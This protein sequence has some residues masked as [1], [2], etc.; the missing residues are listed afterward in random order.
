MPPNLSPSDSQLVAVFRRAAGLAAMFTSV[1][2]AL[3]L[4]GWAANSAFLES[5]LPGQGTMK[6]LTA[7]ALLLAGVALWLLRPPAPAGPVPAGWPRQ[8]GLICAGVVAALGGLVLLEYLFGLNLGLDLALF[9][10][11]VLADPGLPAG[12]PAPATAL[13]LLL[14]GG[15]LLALAIPPGRRALDWLAP[16]AAMAAWVVAGLMLLGYVYE[17]T[18][19]YQIGPYVPMAPSTALTLA[20][21][22]LGVL[23][24]QPEGPLLRTVTTPLA[25]GALSRRLLP[26]AIGLPVVLGWLRLLGQRRALF[27]VGFGGALFAAGNIIVFGGLVY[28]TARLL[29]QSDARRAASRAAL[30]EREERLRVLADATPNGLIIVADSGEIT[31]VNQRAETLFGFGP[32]QL[33]GRFIDALVPGRYREAHPL[34]RAAFVADRRARPMGAGR[35]LIGLRSDG[36]EFP[37]E[38]G[39]SPIQTPQGQVTLASIID[40]T[41]RQRAVAALRQAEERFEKAF[42]ASPAALAVTRLADGLFVDVND[43]FLALLGYAHTEVIG[44]TVAGLGIYP[45]PAERDALVARLQTEG[46]VRNRAT[47]LLTKTGERRSVLLSVDSIELSGEAHVLAILI[48]DTERRRA[49]EALHQL[50]T[51]LE[52]RVAQR[53][54]A[55]AANEAKLRALFEVL[56]VGVSIHDAQLRILESNPALSRITKR[57]QADL[58][59]RAYAS[60]RLIRSDG[61]PMPTA[62][63]ASVQALAEQRPVLNVET[64]AINATGEILWLDVSAAPLPGDDPGVVVVSADITKRKQAEADLQAVNARLRFF[65]DSN[66]VGVA[67]SDEQGILIETNDYYLS[68]LG[69][70]RREYE[71]GLVNWQARTPPEYQPVDARAMAELKAYGVCTPFEKEYL[72]RDG[73]RTWAYLSNALLPDGTI[74]AFI[75][76]IT[77]RKRFEA[78]LIQ[79]GQRQRALFEEAQRQA[80]ELTLRDMMHQALALDRPLTEILRLVVSGIAETL[81]YTQVSLYLREG[82]TLKLQHQVGYHQVIAS[83][84]ISAGIS[85]RVVRT[86]QAVLLEDVRSDPAFLGAIEGITSEICV[87]LFER[88]Q[89]AGILNLE[90]THGRRLTAADLKLMLALGEQVDF[91]LGRARLAAEARESQQRFASAFNHASIGMALVA[92]DGRWLQVNP[93]LCRLV[94][95]A[96]DELLRSSF[97]TITHP[98]DLESDL[99]YG[100]Q[101]LAGAIP[102]YQMEKRYLHK[103]GHIVWVLLSVSLVRDPAGQPHYFISQIEDITERKTAEQAL[104]AQ[105]QA[106]ATERD[107]MQALMDSIPDTIYF[108]DTASRFTRVNRAQAEYLRLPSP[109]GAIGHTDLDFQ[110]PVMAREVFDEE[111]RLVLRGQPL[112]N[113]IDLVSAPDGQPR[114]IS[115][116]KVPLCDAAGQVVGLV[117]ISRDITALK[118]VEARLVASLQEKDVLLKEIHHRVK[119]NLQVI[120]SLLRLQAETL[121]DPRLR[122]AFEDSQRR[123][124]TMA[125]VHEQLYRSTDLA[126][127]DFGE[128]VNG[129]VNYLRRSHARGVPNLRLRVAVE[130]ITLEIDRAI[131]LGLLVNELVTNSLKYAFP[132]ALAEAEIWITAARDDAGTLTVVVGDNGVGVPDTVDLDQPANMGWQLVQSFVSQL[133]ARYTLQ[134]QPG[135]VFTLTIPERKTPRV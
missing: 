51:E 94:G 109:E 50:N 58:S 108:K 70:S 54:A 41:E 55:L 9:R 46:P 128:Y 127:I 13:C 83:V 4:A 63:Y 97:Q 28:G 105:T 23:L 29:N 129:L 31:W 22:A 123:V 80:Q 112:L 130:N 121:D 114:W 88:G 8:L 95:F 75:L 89:V 86:R 15:A 66:I 44:Q 103:R 14:L 25:G 59:A 124:R 11:A 48:D 6:P 61:S 36:R 73:T 67:R 92:T 116:T 113:R 71:A 35:D 12:R 24:A 74:A 56:P 120:S 115:S 43:R 102:S 72:R 2:G 26:A 39:L 40:I 37:M 33:T 68:L 101:M 126:H 49:D 77:E 132:A 7:L 32:G 20:V 87:P 5:L 104:A 107:L 131:P 21:L 98:D 42:R 122:D 91:A 53:T 96:E 27:D 99:E 1:V 45:D 110:E 93:A 118:Q 34:H 81:G 79:S 65:V 30:Q 133:R 38:V 64:G 119:N 117:G 10:E 85:G 135:A 62:E 69:Y 19:I 17:V 134:R 16:V 84:P 57:S 106:L 82:D 111:Q 18:T 78:A 47:T 100:R 125:L 90:S 52:A 76:D 3:V 60:P